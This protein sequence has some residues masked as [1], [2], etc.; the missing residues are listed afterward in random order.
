MATTVAEPVF[1]DTSVV[2]AATVEVHPGHEVAVGFVDDLISAGAPLFLAPQI[3][4]ELLVT[5]TRQPV[6]GRVFAIDEALDVLDVW[7]TG[8]TILE[9]TEAVLRELLRLIERHDVRGKQVHD[10]NLVALMRVHG[11]RRLATRNAA[12]FKRFDREIEVLSV[13]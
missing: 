12:D 1:L 8:S 13:E 2:V 11:V 6:S 7:L 9:E 4:R 5:L 3:A 10:C